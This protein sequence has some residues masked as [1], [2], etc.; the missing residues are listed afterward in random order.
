MPGAMVQNFLG[1][2]FSHRAEREYGDAGE[3]ENLQRLANH[4]RKDILSFRV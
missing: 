3:G 1:G 4:E 2:G